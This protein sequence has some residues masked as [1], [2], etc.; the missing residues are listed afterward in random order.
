MH[1][2]PL[3]HASFASPS[4]THSTLLLC[5]LRCL[6][7]RIAGD[8]VIVSTQTMKVL[9]YVKGAHM[10]YGTAVTFAP[11]ASGL[12]SVSSDAS[13]VVVPL[14]RGAGGGGSGAAAAARRA[15]GGG[16][17]AVGVLGL[18]LALLV[19]LVAALLGTARYAAQQGLLHP[20]HLPA[21]LPPELVSLV[22][23]Q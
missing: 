2:R 18:L 15:G 11:D 16:G 22:T 23:G 17:G 3:H 9:K 14:P 8:I 21:W 7:L 10:V 13:A 4:C 19:L 20:S 12:L 6:L 1:V 5:L